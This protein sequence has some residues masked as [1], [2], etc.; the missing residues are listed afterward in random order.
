MSAIPPISPVS[1]TILVAPVQPIRAVAPTPSQQTD[2][3]G[4]VQA[5]NP[6][7]VGRLLDTTA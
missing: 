5:A 7:G 6:P 1:T 2:K 3:P 4:K